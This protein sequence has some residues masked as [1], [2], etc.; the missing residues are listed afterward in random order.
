MLATKRESQRRLPHRSQPGGGGW[1]ASESEKASEERVGV[2]QGDWAWGIV[3]R[4]SG[5]CRGRGGEGCGEWAGSEVG[6]NEM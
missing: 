6:G 2:C 3:V 5:H 4:R 1:D